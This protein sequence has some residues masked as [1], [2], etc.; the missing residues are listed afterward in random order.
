METLRYEDFDMVGIFSLK[1]SEVE[2]IEEF[3]T[4]YQ[5]KDGQTRYLSRGPLFYKEGMTYDDRFQQRAHLSMLL[6]QAEG[7]KAFVIA[8]NMLNNSAR[9]YFSEMQK[10]IFT[11]ESQLEQVKLCLEEDIHNVRHL[12]RGEDHEETFHSLPTGTTE[13]EGRPIECGNIAL[14]DLFARSMTMRK[15]ENTVVLNPGFGS[16]LIGPYLKEEHG[17]EYENIYL[18]LYAK[19][20]T[21]A[22]KIKALVGDSGKNIK[23]LLNSG[24]ISIKQLSTNP[25]IYT[26][27]GKEFMV[28]DDNMGTGVTLDIL[29][30]AIAR[31]TSAPCTLYGLQAN[32]INFARVT[33]GS[34]KKEQDRGFYPYPGY[35]NQL[36]FLKANLNHNTDAAKVTR[37]DIPTF[38]PADEGKFMS[39]VNFA[40]YHLI[41][42]CVAAIKA[43]D[44]NTY[45]ATLEQYGYGNTVENDM[46][47]LL[48]T[49][50]AVMN[51][52]RIQEYREHMEKLNETQFDNDTANFD[53]ENLPNEL[54]TDMKATEKFFK[55][56]IELATRFDDHTQE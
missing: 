2:G 1:P 16:V 7:K 38:D 9:V 25:G 23:E 20:A 42:D 31:E 21:N 48:S 13:T 17:C 49:S 39:P 52:Y 37:T 22:D 15:P 12:I 33:A 51:H 5:T 28:V 40:D 27:P 24:H 47:V 36:D 46:N 53:S 56:N 10:Q 35:E 30:N 43:G 50:N 45:L 19:N 54:K 14:L 3:V 11:G 44:A 4:P 34:A 8:E 29:R 26:K 55:E 6:T 18:S 41:K 32:W